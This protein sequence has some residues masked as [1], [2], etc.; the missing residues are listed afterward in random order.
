MNGEKQAEYR[1]KIGKP[2]KKMGSN[3]YG[4]FLLEHLKLQ[5]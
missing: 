3:N 2:P 5:Q 1:W 4:L